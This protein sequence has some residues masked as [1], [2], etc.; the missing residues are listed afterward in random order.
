VLFRSTTKIDFQDSGL[1]PLQ[2]QFSFNN[3]GTGTSGDKAADRKSVNAA[4]QTNPQHKI[5]LNPPD[6]AAYPMGA[7]GKLQNLPLSIPDIADTKIAVDVTQPGNAEIVLDFGGDGSYTA[8]TDRRLFATLVAGVN[9]VAWD[10]KDGA[11]K[12][13]TESQF[14]IKTMVSY[15]QGETHFTAYDVEGLDTGF[16]VFTQTASGTTGPNLLFWDDS[17]IPDLSGFA[18]TTKVNTDLG[19]I[20]R[21]PWSNIS[22]GDTNTINTW[23]FAYRDYQT[24][25]VKLGNATPVITSDGGGDTATVKVSTGKTAVT[26]VTATDA[27]S[28]TLTYSLSGGADAALFTIDL[29]TGKLDFKAASV[30]GTYQVIVQVDDGKGRSDT[31]TLTVVADKDTDGDGI[32]DLTDQDDDNDGI[33]DRKSVV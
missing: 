25:L 14:P 4:N 6:P 19:A 12:T 13:V 2:G 1:R 15:T 5:F 18:T 11:G 28:D 3:S 31:Q 27:D 32:F 24:S 16:N 8:G 21:Q 10:G 29:S 23:W 33:P 20:I 26:T 17:N 22:Y 30:S 9:K 7:E